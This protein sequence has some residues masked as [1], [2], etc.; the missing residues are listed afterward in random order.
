MP[1]VQ[2]RVRTVRV[3]YLCDECGEEMRS[4]GYI[5]TSHPP[6][7]P[8]VCANHHKAFLLDTYPSVRYEEETDE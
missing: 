1:E 8:H 3:R 7:Y 5:I 2:R 6:K 4:F